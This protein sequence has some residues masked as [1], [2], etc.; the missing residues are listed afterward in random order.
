MQKTGWTR[1]MICP[2]TSLTYWFP[3]PKQSRR[4][5]STWTTYG[6]NSFPNILQSI[7]KANSAPA[8]DKHLVRCFLL[9]VPKKYFVV[10][11]LRASMVA[12]GSCVLDTIKQQQPNSSVVGK[13]SLT[14]PPSEVFLVLDGVS[15]CGHDVLLF[16]RQDS[17]PF[18]Q[19]GQSVRCSLSLRVL[20]TFQQQL[21]QVSY[22]PCSILL[23][24]RNQRR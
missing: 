2:L 11:V 24:G 9:F 8:R 16:E 22:N 19:A 12:W 3:S 18:D 15:Q 20:V 14:L 10:E 1:G 5:G 23:D 4:C 21:Q 13:P 6:S 7:S 17:E